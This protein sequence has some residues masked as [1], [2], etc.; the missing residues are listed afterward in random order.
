[1]T[2]FQLHAY[3]HRLS[4][5]TASGNLFENAIDLLLAMLCS[6]GCLALQ[7]QILVPVKMTR[8]ND[9]RGSHC[10]TLQHQI[11]EAEDRNDVFQC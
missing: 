4:H 10:L 9:I 1:M 11:I 7:H 6:I 3:L 8:F 5:N 2:C